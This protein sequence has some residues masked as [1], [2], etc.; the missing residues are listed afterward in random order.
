MRSMYVVHTDSITDNIILCCKGGEQMLATN[1]L[2]GGEGG[3]GNKYLWEEWI[4]VPWGNK[5]L[6]EQIFF[7]SSMV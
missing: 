5:Y 7:N 6:G 4:Y 1:F 2:W 3:G